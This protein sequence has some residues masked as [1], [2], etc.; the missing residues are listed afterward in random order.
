MAELA[1]I[2]PERSTAEVELVSHPGAPQSLDALSGAAPAEHRFLRAAWFDGS[3]A[4][5]TL[6]VHRDG[7]PVAAFPTVPAGPPA[8]GACA[9]AG[10][11]WPFRN[12]LLAADADDGEIVRVLGAI[13]SGS[14]LGPL[15]RLGPVYRDDPTAV[16]LARLAPTAGWSV[17]TR[18]LGRTWILDVAELTAKSGTWPRRSTLKRLDGYERTLSACGTLGVERIV[19]T[20]WSSDVLG[21]LAEVERGSWIASAT[22]RSGAKFMLPE[23]RAFWERCIAD[24]V[25]AEMIS[26]VLVRLDGRPIAFSFDLTVG[27]LQY[28]IAGTY[29]AAFG[30]LNVGKLANERNLIWAVE[31]G[32]TRFD[33]GAGDS[34]YKRS[35]GFTAGSEIVDLLFLR[36]PMAAALLRRRWERRRDSKPDDSRRLP[37]SRRQRMLVA[38]LATATAVAAMAE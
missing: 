21:A 37:L 22:D 12:V 23:R 5:A 7:R 27:A 36:N 28:G 33:W 2:A 4:E 18:P 31:R 1:S 9:I 6:L 34:G 11:Y 16:R 29:D 30:A 38:S 13:R 20:G 19:G 17:L 24:P 15:W 3:G 8:L 25:L 14:K 32:V 10:L 35:I 26:A